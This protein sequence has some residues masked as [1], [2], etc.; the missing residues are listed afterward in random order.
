[1]QVLLERPDMTEIDYAE[2]AGNC[3]LFCL[4]FGMS[5]TV[6]IGCMQAQVKNTKGAFC[7]EIGQ[8]GALLSDRKEL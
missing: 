8:T 3:L 5:A 7:L 2:I 4:V 1:M 6:D